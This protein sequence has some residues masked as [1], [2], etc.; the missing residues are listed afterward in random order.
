[1]LSTFKRVIAVTS[2]GCAI[3]AYVPRPY[4][5]IPDGWMR[6]VKWFVIGPDEPE[7]RYDL[8]YMDATGVAEQLHVDLFFAD[9]EGARR[10]LENRMTREELT[11]V[12]RTPYTVMRLQLPLNVPARYV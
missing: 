8:L 4:V 5:R 10:I 6:E 12:D 3:I 1:M 9:P 2:D 11:P 7:Y